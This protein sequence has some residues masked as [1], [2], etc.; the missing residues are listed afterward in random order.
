MEGKDTWNICH[1][2]SL[3]VQL[4]L[5]VIYKK[6]NVFNFINYICKGKGTIKLSPKFLPHIQFQWLRINMKCICRIT[7]KKI[8]L[9]MCFSTINSVPMVVYVV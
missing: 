5:V 3:S 9:N 2:L 7:S 8:N 4:F 1:T 6:I